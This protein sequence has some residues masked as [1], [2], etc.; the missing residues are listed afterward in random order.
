MT[1]KYLVTLTPDERTW[2]TDLISAGKRSA[3]AITRARILLK[4]DQAEGGPGWPDDR[5]A[6]A[7][8]CGLRTVERGRQRFAERGP[9]EA[10]GR[11]RRAAPAARASRTAGPRRASSPWPARRRPTAGPPGP[12]S[13][14]P[15]NSSNYGS[16]TPSPTRRCGAA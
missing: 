9:E 12:C 16:W 11:T 7:L 2:L 15:T 4:A 14:W 3:L 10:L 6:Q 13:C 1:K 5:I 8:D